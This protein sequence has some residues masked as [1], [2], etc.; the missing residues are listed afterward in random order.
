[1][2]RRI[3]DTTVRL[4]VSLSVE[5]QSAGVD[6]YACGVETH[7]EYGLPVDEHG[8]FYETDDQ[9]D[10]T[11]VPACRECFAVHAEH[12]A[13]GLAIRLRALEQIAAEIRR[14]IR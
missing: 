8:D 1:M 14:E 5:R 12:G 6:C 13:A 4:T 3:S 9:G 7:I 10:F 11:I 2:L